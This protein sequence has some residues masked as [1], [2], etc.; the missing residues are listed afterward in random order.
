MSVVQLSEISLRYDR[1]AVL[2]SIELSVDLGEYL[3]V[4]GAS[5]CGKTSLLRMIAGLIPPTT[6]QI[7]LFGKNVLATAPRHRQVAF[8]PQ[9]AGLYPHLTLRK[10]IS[11]GIRD[12][13]SSEELRQR[14]HQAASIVEMDGFL[15]RLPQQLSGGQLRRAAVAKA[16]A[17]RSPVRLLD[18]PLSAVDASLRF[19]IEADLKALHDETPGAT[20]HVT[21]DG[22]EAKRLAS[23]IA[24]I[25]NGRIAQL[26]T[27]GEIESA[28]ATPGVAAALGDSR[29]VTLKIR[30]IESG[31][32]SSDGAAISGP[33]ANIGTEATV[34]YF[35]S[36]AV[37]LDGSVAGESG[38][39]VDR[40]RGVVVTKGRL[41]WFV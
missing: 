26:G 27:P 16:I 40:Q 22:A 39:L 38:D 20:I 35:E 12:R 1:V 36:D 28:P 8:V 25:E 34:G 19:Q 31:W 33:D 15:D 6:G 9:H 21:H 24:V 5:G 4:L 11:L 37:E 23:R 2:D 3:V 10:S 7:F 29:F 17:S 30:R 41:M 18:E 32:S 13:L 14:V